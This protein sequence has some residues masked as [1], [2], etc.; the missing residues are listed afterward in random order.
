MSWV[1]IAAVAA[2]LVWFIFV[3]ST[4]T[5]SIVPTFVLTVAAVATGIAA[6]RLLPKGAFRH[7]LAVTALAVSLIFTGA[8]A[9]LLTALVHALSQ[10]P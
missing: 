2:A 6:V 7:E 8:M 4:Q 3:M 10:D 9:L 5:V 1:S